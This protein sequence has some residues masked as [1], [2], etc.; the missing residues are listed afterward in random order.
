VILYIPTFGRVKQQV[1]LANIPEIIRKRVILVV[2]ES[3]KDAF[4]G[5]R[6]M[7]VPSDV[8]GIAAK[9]QFIMEN[10]DGTKFG[11]HIVMLDDDLRFFI[12][13]LDDPMKFMQANNA[14]I[15]DM[16][17]EI[18]T[19][20]LEFAH[21]GIL[22]R[23]GGN[24]VNT[25]FL[26]NTRMMR[27][28]AYDVN[29]FRKEQIDF[30]RGG[31]MCDFDVTLQLLRKGYP[32]C[33]LTS[34][35]QDQGSSNAPGGCSITRTSEVQ[36]ADAERLHDNHPQFVKLVTKTTKFAWGGQDRTDVRIQWKKA[37]NADR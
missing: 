24:R 34:W 14:Q 19:Q 21:V 12:R 26:F 37:L 1:T 4:P 9:R 8:H 31:N 17:N 15:I 29:V 33:V 23:E 13:R 5:Q 27:V 7:V 36:T 35:V 20:L 11:P 10:H 30:T 22:G 2:Y 25:P 32:N 6:M 18:G 16:F 28:L 3:E